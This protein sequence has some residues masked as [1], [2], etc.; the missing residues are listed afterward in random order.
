MQSQSTRAVETFAAFIN[1]NINNMLTIDSK[2][3]SNGLQNEPYMKPKGRL[4]VRYEPDTKTLFIVQKDFTRWCADNY[5]NAKEI[6]VLFN[7]ETGREVELIK[8]RMGAG[9]DTD[10]GPVSVYCI[11]D[12]AQVLGLTDDATAASS[13]ET[14]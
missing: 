7:E 2:Q 4:V 8:K 14:A 1:N 13:T 11:K 12:A 5:I 9:W 6:R 3:R 10:F